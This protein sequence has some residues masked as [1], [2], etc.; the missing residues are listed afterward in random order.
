M[1]TY[2]SIINKLM[3]KELMGL[4]K[5]RLEIGKKHLYMVRQFSDNFDGRTLTLGFG[6]EEMRCEDI[7]ACNT[8]MRLVS[9]RNKTTSPVMQITCHICKNPVE[10]MHTNAIEQKS[11]EDA[12]AGS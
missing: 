2:G 11:G 9:I 12:D 8:C 10:Y 5:L 6:G 3:E 1:R 4:S 7:Y